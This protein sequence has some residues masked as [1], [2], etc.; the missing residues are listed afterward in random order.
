MKIKELHLRNIA[1]IETADIDFEKDLIDGVTGDPASVFLISGDTGAGKSVILDGI[2]MALYKK[3]PRIAGVA[4]IKNNEFKD[5]AGEAIRVADITQYTRLGISE[6]DDCYSEVVFIGNDGIEYRAKIELGMSRG[7]TGNKQL[8]H[9]DTSWKIKAGSEDWGKGSEDIIQKAVGLS[10]EQFGRMAML[11]QGQFAAFLTGDKKEREAI[12]EQLTATGHFTS[13]GAAIK[14]LHDKA[15]SAM[16]DAQ[17]RYDA[18][19]QHIIGEEEITALTTEKAEVE[20][21]KSAI[22]EKIKA[23]E[24][25]IFQVRVIEQAAA[26][27]TDA[28]R[29]HSELMAIKA[30]E[31]YKSRSALVKDWDSSSEERQRLAD[32]RLAKARIEAVK[33]DEEKCQSIFTD[34]TA[35]LEFRAAELRNMGDPKAAVDECQ[36]KIDERGRKR[37]ELNPDGLRKTLEQINKDFAG[38]GKIEFEAAN[39]V[40]EKGKIRLLESQINSE[41]ASLTGLGEAFNKFDAE[42]KTAKEKEAETSGRYSIMSSSIDKSMVQI[43]Q[44]LIAENAETCPLCGQRIEHIHIDEEFRSLLAPLKE[45]Q[46]KAKDA[47]SQAERSRDEAKAAYD[48]ADGAI[49]A[50][51]KECLSR[52]AAVE[53]AQRKLAENA[54]VFGIAIDDA[55]GDNI[56]AVKQKL[57]ER[58]QKCMDDQRKAEDLQ[59]SINAKLEEKKR[60]DNAL[61][62]FNAAS[63]LIRNISETRNSILESQSGWDKKVTPAEYRCADI[64]KEWASLLSKVFSLKETIAAQQATIRQCEAQLGE[65]YRNTGKTES[66][67]DA[68]ASK[69][70]EVAPAKAFLQKTDADLKSRQDAIE[71]ADAHI[72]EAMRKLGVAEM[73]NIPAKE[74]LAKDKEALAKENESIVSRLQSIKDKLDTNAKN[75]ERLATLDKELEKARKKYDR[76]NLLNGYFGGTRFRTLVQTYIL[77]PLLNNANIYLEKITDRY[78][79]TCSEDNE[80]LSI[81]VLDKYNK[82]QIRSV[83]VLSGGERFM[84][85]L[86]LSL[87]LSSLNRQDMNVNILFIDEGF[88]TLDEKSLDSVME[89]LEKL[90]EIAGQSGRRVGIISH[91]EELYERIPVQ[92]QV[93]KKGE[94]R[95]RVTVCNGGSQQ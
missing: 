24:S 21:G 11:A 32:L 60:L 15:K 47:L 71:T 91:R 61:R 79:L 89:T 10:F 46:K 55:F 50:K 42:F 59:K 51:K 90:Q 94:G 49:A 48:K 7:K 36:G 83:T 86:A 74:D 29:R 18:E 31:E 16:M 66:D 81:L 57:E 33:I 20:K 67:L 53:V 40:A 52:S 39:I 56:A 3:T 26:T 63:E 76:W 6:K 87:A 17:I 25:A 41:T 64:R 65:Y 27:K 68:V 82:N 1:S 80:Q 78:S 95:S 23:N 9:K 85:S 4:N 35:D 69:K 34:L 12:L 19:K 62:Q 30:S 37:T 43:R 8:K 14:S 58:K 70:A 84:I 38:L 45:E 22:D 77:R 28:E 72:K 2:S 75:A 5:A 73:S 13:Y 54:S 92:I 93:K 88:G 44:R